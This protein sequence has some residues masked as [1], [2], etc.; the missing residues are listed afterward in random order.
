MGAKEQWYSRL[1]YIY[2]NVTDNEKKQCQRH[3]CDH[4]TE[5]N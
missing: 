4:V 5:L 2:Y 3:R 1:H